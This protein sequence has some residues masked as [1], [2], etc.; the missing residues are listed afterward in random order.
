MKLTIF[1]VTTIS[2]LIL[3]SAVLTLHMEN[4]LAKPCT[5]GYLPERKLRHREAMRVFIELVV[6][7]HTILLFH[8]YMVSVSMTSNQ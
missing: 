8:H 4:Q 5:G 1:F 3:I 6:D 7:I 2:L